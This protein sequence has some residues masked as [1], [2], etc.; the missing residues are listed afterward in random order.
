MKTRAVP[1]KIVHLEIDGPS[2]LIASLA[3]G[4]RRHIRHQPPTSLYPWVLDETARQAKLGQDIECLRCIELEPPENLVVY[5]KTRIFSEDNIPSGL[6][7]AHTTKTG[8]W[9]RLI[10]LEGV[11][12][13]SFEEPVGLTVRASPDHPVF[14]PPNLRHALTPCGRTRLYVEFLRCSSVESGA[15]ELGVEPS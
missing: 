4:H 2:A 11:A 15:E 3:C 9:G 6:R 10:V 14:V 7:R 1:R 13:L 12:E 5:K 8:T